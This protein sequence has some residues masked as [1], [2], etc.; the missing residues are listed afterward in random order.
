M[1]VEPELHARRL[2]VFIEAIF[3]HRLQLVNGGDGSRALRH[4]GT[5]PTVM[6]S[7]HRWELD[8]G[9]MELA[10]VVEQLHTQS[11]GEALYRTFCGTIGALERNRPEGESGP[12]WTNGATISVSHSTERSMCHRHIQG[13]ASVSFDDIPQGH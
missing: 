13:M 10:P 6:G 4:L 9:E 11:F 1:S 12:I 2:Y 3:V 8:G 5:H 7:V